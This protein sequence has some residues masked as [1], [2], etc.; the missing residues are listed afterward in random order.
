MANDELR[1]VGQVRL[2]G[3]R[4]L[5]RNLRKAGYDMTDVKDAHKEAADSVARRGAQ[6]APV[7]DSD[8][9]GALRRS[10]RGSGSQ[11]RSVI[12]GG[13]RRR[14]AAAV[15]YAPPIHW[16]WPKRNIKANPFLSEAAQE[17]EPQWLNAFYKRMNEI[18][19]KAGDVAAGG[20]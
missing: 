1:G 18:V 20:H 7:G 8:K 12:R 19:D 9:A 10:I 16:G 3:T 5:R 14:G 6:K 15:P 4:Q 13:N 11:T 17:T 2:R